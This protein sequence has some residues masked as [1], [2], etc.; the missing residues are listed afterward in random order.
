MPTSCVLRDTE[1]E[2]ALEANSQHP[3]S[4]SLSSELISPPRGTPGLC[5]PRPSGSGEKET[6]RGLSH[7][8]ERRRLAYSGANSLGCRVHSQ[9]VSGWDAPCLGGSTRK[10]GTCL[11]SLPRTGQ[12]QMCK[13]EKAAKKRNKNGARNSMGR[14]Q[15]TLLGH[16]QK[17]RGPQ[18]RN[19]VPELAPNLVLLCLGS[20]RW[21][22]V[23]LGLGNSE[24]LR[25]QGQPWPGYWCHGSRGHQI[26]ELDAP[27]A[28]LPCDGVRNQSSGSAPR[29]GRLAGGHRE[30]AGHTVHTA[31]LLKARPAAPRWEEV[32][33]ESVEAGRLGLDREPTCW[34]WKMGR[35]FPALLRVHLP[36]RGPPRRRSCGEHLRANGVFGGDHGR[37]NHG[38]THPPSV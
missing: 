7:S 36:R 29:S 13:D 38:G 11:Y 34:T 5:H 33:R 19:Q 37:Q 25:F 32:A 27:A 20:H 2:C 3:Q 15:L 22:A 16:H 24:S 9:R 18:L 28:L 21:V 30:A 12:I 31:R 17:V 1:L 23:G 10:W 8:G 4:S 14:K 35:C 6:E 26:R